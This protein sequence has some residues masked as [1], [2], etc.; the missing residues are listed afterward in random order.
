MDL[1]TEITGRA[2]P[3]A[4]APQLAAPGLLAVLALAAVAVAWW[5]AWRVLRLVV[6]LVHELGHAVVGVAVG[7]RFRGF[8]LRA[9]MSGHAVT[10][11]RP[12]GPGLVVTTWAGYPAPALL[13]MLLVWLAAKGWTAPVLTALLAG[14]LV[15]LVF[16]R[17]ALTGLVVV[18]SLAGVAALWWWR[19]DGLQQHVL[20]GTGLVLL[21]GA[22]RHLAS[23]LRRVGP[24]SDPGA[25][26]RLTGIPVLVWQV[27]FVAVLALA[28]W[29][30]GSEVLTVLSR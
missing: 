30:V 17:S 7:R 1:L 24:S 2:V 29:I 4:R 13:G 14:L 9:D 5:P 22:W 11:G 28:S 6:T 10:V 20:V 23:V 15:A 19:E 18:G 27:G 12:S 16:V 3:S 26:A 21:A 25:L 8:V